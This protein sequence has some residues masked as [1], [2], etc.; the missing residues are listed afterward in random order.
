MRSTV[1]PAIST[2][3]G[4]KTVFAA[5][6]SIRAVIIGLA[7]DRLKSVA[8]ASISYCAVYKRALNRRRIAAI[9]LLTL[10]SQLVAELE[11]FLCDLVTMDHR[12]MVH[13]PGL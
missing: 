8:A 9:P 12:L 4:L 6:G 2:A 10:E 11:T 1:S 13:S 5:Y 3:A 7:G